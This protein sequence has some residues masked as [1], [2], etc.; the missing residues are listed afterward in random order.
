[1]VSRKRRSPGRMRAERRTQEGRLRHR[2][3]R[4]PHYAPRRRLPLHRLER[5]RPPRQA[6]AAPVRGGGGPRHLHPRRL[7]PTRWRFG[8]AATE[9]PLREAASARRSTYVG[10]AN[11]D[12]VAIIPF[13]DRLH[14]SHAADARQERASSRCSS[15][16]ASCEHGGQTDLADVHEDVRRAEQAARARGRDLATSTIRTASSRAS[17]CSATTSSSRSCSRSTTSARPTPNAARRPRARRLR[18]RRRARGDGLASRCSRR[19]SAS[20]RST[21]RSS[22][23]SARSARCRSSAR[24]P[25][26]PF[27]ELVLQDLPVGRLPAVSFLGPIPLG[28]RGRAIAVGAAAL[29]I[30]AYIIK[31]RRRRFEVPF[32]QLWKRVLEQK[33]ANALWKQLKR[34]LSLLLMLL[35]LGARPV[36]RARPD[37]RRGSTQGAQ[38]RRSCSTRR[39]R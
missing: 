7:P 28:D 27:D 20:T 18:D 34:L 24:T 8:D 2:V 37:A 11:L 33:D 19:T 12:R 35:I 21:A 23:R 36:R 3:R 16:C 29:A 6:A 10:L 14:R 22:R 26:I 1:M 15:S 17:T 39:R 13:A 25:S 30:G 32:S 38:R 9:A 31:M 5:L 4:P